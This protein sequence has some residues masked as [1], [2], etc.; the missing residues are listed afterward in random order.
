[1]ENIT[2]AKKGVNK[3]K[4]EIH[5]DEDS[6]LHVS[7]NEEISGQNNKIDIRTCEVIM[8]KY[9]KNKIKKEL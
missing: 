1:M 5:I 4:V 6:I 8:N 3:I 7:A 9:E 2:K